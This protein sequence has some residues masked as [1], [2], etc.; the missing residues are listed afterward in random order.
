MGIVY[1][2][3]TVIARQAHRALRHEGLY[4]TCAHCGGQAWTPSQDFGIVVVG[5]R[6]IIEVSAL[7]RRLLVP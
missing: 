2:T 7:I 3:G 4:E 6:R 1:G 5:G